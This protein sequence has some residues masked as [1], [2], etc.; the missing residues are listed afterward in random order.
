MRLRV[1][2][3]VPLFL[4]PLFFYLFFLSHFFFFFSRNGVMN[5]GMH[6]PSGV[7][8]HYTCPE[9][10]ALTSGHDIIGCRETRQ[11]RYFVRKV[12]FVLIHNQDRIW[13]RVSCF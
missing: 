3:L 4:F 12:C 10:G 13:G 2:F 9:L 7:V 1:L 6:T 11:D 8:G 5:F